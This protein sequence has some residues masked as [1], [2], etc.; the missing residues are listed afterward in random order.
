MHNIE[1]ELLLKTL[2]KSNFHI[3]KKKNQKSK[4]KKYI[5]SRSPFKYN[6]TKEQFGLEFQLIKITI[7]NIK[8]IPK[9]FEIFLKNIFYFSNKFIFKLTKKEFFFK[10]NI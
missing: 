8:Y 3:L 4:I 7:C 2:N 5:I 6:K 10:G 1:Y 9:I